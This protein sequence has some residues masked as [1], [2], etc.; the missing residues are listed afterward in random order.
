MKKLS[1]LL[2]SLLAVVMF[3]ACGN[4]DEPVNKQNV[5]MVINN[6]AIDGDN[7]VFS[8]GE[9]K[10]ELNYTD[11]FIKFTANYKDANGQSHSLTTPDMKMTAVSSTVYT[12]NNVASSTFTGIDAF[13]GYIDLASGMMWYSFDDG[14]SHVVSTTQ[15]LYA[16]TTTSITNPENGNHYSH[17]QSA[18]LFALDAR[19]ETCVMKISNFAPNVVGSVQVTEIQ[20]DGLTVTPTTTGYIITADEVESSYRGFYKITDVNFTLDSQCQVISG[21]F[22]CNNLDFAITG[23]LFPNNSSTPID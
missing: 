3:T 11:M 7:L 23:K 21:S 4:D 18:Y 8:Q 2:L 20:Y 19:G 1:L 9:A 12:F 17:E 13:V 15:L 6:R 10:V 16:Y 14:T 22:K 5:T